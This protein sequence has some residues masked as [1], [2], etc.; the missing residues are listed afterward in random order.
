MTSEEWTIDPGR[1]EVRFSLRHLVFAKVEGTIA[2]LEGKVRYDMSDPFTA[3]VTVRLAS[4]SVTTG[5]PE[6]DD[7]VRSAEFL[8]VAAFPE[9]QFESGRISPLAE[10]SYDVVGELRIRDRARPVTLHVQEAP[11]AGRPD[12][13]ASPFGLFAA[14]TTINRQE[15]GLHWNQDLDTGGVV[16]GDKVQIAIKLVIGARAGAA[17]S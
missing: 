1:S 9:I 14:T 8:D 2:I 11:A 3:A 17:A 6:R 12:P 13:R 15:F 16:L 10:G 4:A 5:D 7:H